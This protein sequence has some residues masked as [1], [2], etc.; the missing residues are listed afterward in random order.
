[1]RSEMITHGFPD[2]CQIQVRKQKSG[3][4]VG[5]EILSGN[6]LTITGAVTSEP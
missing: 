4:T 3:L 5:G 6:A 2:A 1:M